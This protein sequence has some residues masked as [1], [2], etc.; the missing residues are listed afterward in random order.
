[1]S[2]SKNSRE[3]SDSS[4]SGE[5]AMEKGPTKKLEENPKKERFNDY[6]IPLSTKT[7]DDIDRHPPTK[8]EPQNVTSSNIFNPEQKI[9]T[10]KQ[11]GQNAPHSGNMTAPHKDLEPES[12]SP[13]IFLDTVPDFMKCRICNDVFESPQLLSC[14]GTNICKM[15]MDRHLQRLA[16]LADQQP[17]CPFCRSTEFELVHN[18]ALEHSISQ[19]KVKCCYQHK[20]CG[21]VGI[22]EK[23]N[24]HLK[25]CAFVPIDCPNRCGCE[26]FKRCKLSDHMLS[27]PHTHTTCSF[28]TIGCDEKTLLVREAAQKHANNY[29]SRHLLLVAQRNINL[30]KDYRH[31]CTSLQS[32][33]YVSIANDELAESQRESLAATKCN[34]K[35]LKESLQE[36][37]RKIASLKTDLNR[38]EIC[39]KGIKRNIMEMNSKEAALRDS[40]GEVQCSPVPKATDMSCPPVTFTIE[41]FGRRMKVN[42]MWLSPP[43]Y[44]HVGGYKMCLS[45]V[46]AKSRPNGTFVSVSIHFLAGEFDEHL[47]WPFPGAIF[48]IT[49]I[50]QQVIKCNQSVHLELVGKDTLYIRSKQ[51]NGSLGYGYSSPDFLPHSKMAPFLSRN[52]CFKLMMY[53]IQF[54]PI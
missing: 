24:L 39:L 41:N 43:F 14:C 45:V 40:V 53:R 11:A 23:G 3:N 47:I 49:A 20:G 29:R 16:T 17:S 28:E 1:M 9:F 8:S 36:I 18:A 38:E 37:Q 12:D 35:S 54:L 34:I 10:L 25:E 33:S 2:Q 21:W 46:P 7:L 19:L 15:C 52:N 50:S 32:E 26:P 22:L 42:D 30:L 27:C 48:T 5:T 6:V 4:R 44:T 13:W 51:I 31:F